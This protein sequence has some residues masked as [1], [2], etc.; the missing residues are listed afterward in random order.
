MKTIGTMKYIRIAVLALMTVALSS[1][2]FAQN[3]RNQRNAN[4]NSGYT[5]SG[6]II[7]AADGT[8]LELVNIILENNS[9][10]A[11]SDLEG[12]FSLKLRNG[13]YH[14]EVSYI[15]YETVKG[16]LKVDGKDIS[17]FNVKLQASSLA[18]EEVVVTAKQQAMG[19]SSVI[20][21]A[22]LQHLQP[23]SV[24]DMLQLLPGN[25]TKNPDVNSIGQT[26]IREVSGSSNNAMGALVMVDGA[27]I[28]NDA[29][30]QLLSTS[31]SGS[32]LNSSAS[33]GQAS[34]GRGVDLRIISTDNIENMEV[35][36]GI[37]SVEYGNL[38]SGAV[39]IKTKRGATPLEAKAKIDPESKMFYAGKGFTLGTGG[40]INLALDYT[41]SY[42]DVRFPAKGFERITGDVS[43]GRTFFT[44]YPLS[45][46]V[47]VSYY[48][49]VF[50]IRK[51]KQQRSFE[52]TKSENRGIRVNLNGDWNIKRALISNLSYNI[53]YSNSYQRDY[54][55][56]QILLTTGI[57]PVAVSTVSG[58]F[59]SYMLNGTYQSEHTV[60]GN[61]VDLFAQL[62]G[63][64]TIFISEGFT[65]SFK[66]GVEFNY[67]VNHGDGLEFDPKRP[68]FVRN[69][70]TVR[71]RPYSDVPAMQTLS[72]FIENKTIMPIGG[73]NLTAQVGIRAN[74][75][76]I[77]RN[78]LDRSDMV[79]VEP[80]FNVEWSFLTPRNSAFDNFSISAGWGLTSKMPPLVYLY[81]DK[82]YFDDKSFS[83]VE[84]GMSM[85]KSIAIMTTSVIEDTSNPDL[86]PSTGKKFELGLNFE[87]KKMS[88][89]VTFFMEKYEN[90]FSYR[91]V[92][93]T[94][95]YRTYL[96]PA[97]ATDYQYENGVLSC[98]MGTDRI[99]V[100]YRNDSTFQSYNVPMNGNSTQKMG[101]EYTLNLGQ[102]K[103]L[104]TSV[105]V[106]GA[107]LWVKRRNEL[108]YWSTI[109]VVDPVVDGR[110][111][112]KKIYPFQPF[113]PAGSGSIESRLNT[114]LRFITHIPKLSLIF[115]T[116]AQIIW[117]ET[118]QTVY[119]DGDGNDIWYLA[120][121]QQ[122]T[123]EDLRPNV[124]PAY[125]RDFAGNIY[126][127]NTAYRSKANYR[128]EYEMVNTYTYDTYF[129][130]T[131]YPSSVIINFRLTKQF[132]DIL[133]VSFM[134]NNLFN[135]RKL[136]RDPNDGSYTNLAIPQYFGAELKIKI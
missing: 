86:K 117:S 122:S 30:M 32:S 17:N 23:K 90:E 27:P 10:W 40:T 9:F 43:Y 124:D 81:P 79:T 130:K 54:Q 53:S 18:L 15:G 39:L 50:D 104:R 60:K 78:Y 11:V 84:P 77:D 12:K 136:Y 110:S 3:A 65:S 132:S 89:N 63:T 42:N 14:Y 4:Q 76:F 116:T 52:L 70:Q 88:G 94:F 44:Q 21:Q 28:A 69:A 20:D 47:K 2:S 19:S 55:L 41:E 101:V 123:T 75:L 127:W 108:G 133:E 115:S 59:R 45:F 103:A 131:T 56:Q 35:I 7:D 109:S 92:P 134:A 107:W 120:Q 106:D 111:N 13:E 29:T 135:T 1:N 99:N 16:V 6:R 8:P 80:R 34:T 46:N 71:P 100:D 5:V 112:P 102:I 38:T 37:P 83:Y 119:K 91:S 126:E 85:D 129:N 62:K 118:G 57:T 64:K 24:E 74:R 125:F 105:V 22:A 96:P 67:D 73:T 33:T 68:P 49:N 25:V 72:G 82:A 26:Y 31:K 51:D 58:E 121:N 113:Y 97:G 61:P 128:R 93:Y 66:E 98:L 87:F 48:Q 95:T 114:N 36:R